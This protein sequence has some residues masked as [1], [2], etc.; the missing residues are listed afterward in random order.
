MGGNV[1][2]KVARMSQKCHDGFI[3][4]VDV[5]AREKRGFNIVVWTYQNGK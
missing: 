4:N 1:H 3:V 5:V 2:G